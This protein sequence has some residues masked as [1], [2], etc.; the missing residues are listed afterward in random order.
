LKEFLYLPILRELTDNKNK[1]NNSIDDLIAAL[2]T[3]RI[4]FNR[5]RFYGKFN[6][7][8]S[9]DLKHMGAKWDGKTKSFILGLEKLPVHLRDAV[10]LTEDRFQKAMEKVDMAMGK[11]LPRDI[12]KNMQLSNIFDKT[13]FNVDGKIES[14]MAGITVQ[15]KI[16]PEDRETIR[17]DYTENMELY[18]QNWTE[19]EIIRLRK[20]MDKRVLEG[21][22]FEG[23]IEVL[24][25]RYGVSKN[26]AKFWARQETKLLTS[27]LKEIRYIKAGVLEYEWRNV[28]GSPNHPV[29]PMHA[30]LNRT[31]Q[32]WD[33]P[34]IVNEKGERKHPG[35][36][37]NCRCTAS[38]IVRVYE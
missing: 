24:Q 25:K 36:D 34:P 13:I 32:R 11:I 4:R 15:Q 17:K 37:F 23:M 2:R 16:T 20:I 35:E 21:Y 22:R 30:K 10:R 12:T 38:P 8:I 7:K 27:K 18:I 26:K 3:G 6:A 33:S 14:S 5:G 31:I 29:R 28:I 19:K 9:L 1:I